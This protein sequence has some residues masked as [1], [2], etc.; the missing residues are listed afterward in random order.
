MLD[1]LPMRD[2]RPWLPM[3]AARCEDIREWAYHT[4][5]GCGVARL[6]VWDTSDGGFFAVVTAAGDGLSVTN[7]AD[8]IWRFLESRYG[9]PLG[10]AEF[11]P[12][13]ESGP[14]HA[15]LVLPPPPRG[16]SP[17]WLALWPVPPANPLSGLLGFWW[18]VNGAEI[19]AP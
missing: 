1:D 4:P 18:D 6:R 19:L 11:W 7:A 5:E 14:A 9:R 12:E 8:W 10:L 2:G 17:G 15:D 3:L 13:G 16:A